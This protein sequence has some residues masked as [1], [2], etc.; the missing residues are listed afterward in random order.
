MRKFYGYFIAISFYLAIVAALLTRSDVNL[1][2][3]QNSW[4]TPEIFRRWAQ[5]NKNRLCLPYCLRLLL[6][7]LSIDS[8]VREATLFYRVNLSPK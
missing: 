7:W 5:K 3:S 4:L 6:R 1:S 8:I 2:L